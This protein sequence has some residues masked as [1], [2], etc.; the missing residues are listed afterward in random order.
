M[1]LEE[2]LGRAQRMMQEIQMRKRQKCS[3]GPGGGVGKKF[4]REQGRADKG[5]YVDDRNIR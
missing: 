5:S 2:G 1:F 4:A 3:P